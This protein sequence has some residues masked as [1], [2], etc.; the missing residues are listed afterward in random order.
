M[1]EIGPAVLPRRADKFRRPG[2]L[3]KVLVPDF[4]QVIGLTVA[5]TNPWVGTTEKEQASKA[6]RP[7]AS[8]CHRCVGAHVTAHESNAIQPQTIDKAEQVFGEG[9]RW[10]PC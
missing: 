7:L 9:L 4:D 6:F 10:G 5:T 2:Q 8:K 1:F 3:V